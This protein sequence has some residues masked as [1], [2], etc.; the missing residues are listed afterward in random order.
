[1]FHISSPICTLQQWLCVTVWWC[2]CLRSK[3]A[4]SVTLN[5]Y[6]WMLNISQNGHQCSF[7]EPQS[8]K[9]SPVFSSRNQVLRNS[10][11][12]RSI[13]S[14]L[15]WKFLS[16][17]AIQKSQ[18]AKTFLS[19]VGMSTKHIQIRMRFGAF[20][21]QM[22]WSHWILEPEHRELLDCACC[23]IRNHP[24]KVSVRNQPKMLLSLASVPKMLPV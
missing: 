13:S 1:M 10:Y 5:Q 18:G 12:L 11:Q 14:F 24:L 15:P 21:L 22:V 17:Q 19:E 2:T 3:R 9:I 7:P 6:H 4:M 16:W 8:R 20:G 23:L